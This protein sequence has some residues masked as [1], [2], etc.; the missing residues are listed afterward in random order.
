MFKHWRRTIKI[1]MNSSNIFRFFYAS[2]IVTTSAFKL[3][4]FHIIECVLFFVFII[5]VIVFSISFMCGMVAGNKENDG[6]LR[7]CVFM[8]QI[9]SVCVCVC[10]CGFRWIECHTQPRNGRNSFPFL[11]V[12]VYMNVDSVCILPSWREIELQWS[13]NDE[14]KRRRKKKQRLWYWIGAIAWR[15]Q[16]CRQQRQRQRQR[17]RAERLKWTSFNR[18]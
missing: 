6:W 17:W 12:N 9:C 11:F 14:K 5:R 4:Q 3:P 16:R 15:P 13:N 10:L 1:I 2:S 8:R 7:F 18:A